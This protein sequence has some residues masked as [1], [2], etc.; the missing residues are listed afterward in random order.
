MFAQSNALNV[1]VICPNTTYLWL[2]IARSQKLLAV[3][4]KRPLIGPNLISCFS[5]KQAYLNNNKYT[6]KNDL[7]YLHDFVNC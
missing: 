7:N 5:I 2:A 6:L 3:L 1:Y 4:K